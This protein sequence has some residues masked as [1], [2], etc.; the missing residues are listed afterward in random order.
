MRRAAL[1]AALL[2]LAVAALTAGGA[3]GASL[4]ATGT[5]RAA[6]SGSV[7]VPFGPV[8]AAVEDP[9]PTTTPI[10]TTT[11]TTTPTPTTEQREERAAAPGPSSPPT[12][13]PTAP[14]STPASP[15][16]PVSAGAP[17]PSD[18]PAPGQGAETAR[19]T[20]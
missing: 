19:S 4:A 1:P 7:E 20:S 9:T 2:A 11:P 14:P 12:R 6:F 18:A 13:S 16:A 8:A 3:V 15:S 17:G 5:T 10:P